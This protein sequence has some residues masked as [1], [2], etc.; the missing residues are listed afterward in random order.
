[1]K[2]TSFLFVEELQRANRIYGP[3]FASPHEGYAIMREELEE[4]WE[5]IKKK[6]P[7]KLRMMEEAIQVGAMAMKFIQSLDHWSWLG[8]KMSAQELKC[9]QCRY[10]VITS[11]I[12][13][14]L[15][16]DPCLTCNKLNQWKE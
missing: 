15:E 2:K 10:R 14:D 9:L 12:L 7:D 8:L 1:M 3:S 13:A 4:L 6:R 16:S 5:E 11:D